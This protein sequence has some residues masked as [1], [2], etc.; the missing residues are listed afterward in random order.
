[1]ANYK[2]ISFPEGLLLPLA[3]ALLVAAGCQGGRNAPGQQ[4]QAAARLPEDSNMKAKATQQAAKAYPANPRDAPQSIPPGT[5]RLVGKVVAILDQRDA[6]KLTPCGQ[7][8]CRARVRIERLVGYGAAFQPL[9]A[10]GQEIKVYFA[11]T[12]S[13]TGKYFPE[14]ATPLPG[15]RCPAPASPA[16][17]TPTPTPATSSPAC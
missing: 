12:L 8:P 6:D 3:V 13:P 4:Q 7:V 17:T 11:F 16:T 5:C 2:T 10:A 15:F 1:L 14:L 9:L